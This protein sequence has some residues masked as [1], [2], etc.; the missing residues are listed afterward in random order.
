[1]ITSSPTEQILLSSVVTMF[2]AQA[3]AVPVFDSLEV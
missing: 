2:A 1:M 3:S